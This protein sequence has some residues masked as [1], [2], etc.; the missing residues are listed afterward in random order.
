MYTLT[1]DCGKK[2]E[3]ETPEGTEAATWHH[4]L[5][6]HSDMIH[7]MTVEQ[8]SEALRANH[9]ALGLHGHH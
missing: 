5:K 1:C 3:G 7:K 2:V 8:L 6:D 4:V 9:E